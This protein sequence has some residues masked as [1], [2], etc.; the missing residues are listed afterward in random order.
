MKKRNPLFVAGFPYILISI[1]YVGMQIVT[2]AFEGEN[3]SPSIISVIGLISAIIL[4]LVGAIYGLY[5]LIDTAKVLRRE[6]GQKIPTAFLLVIPIAN[7][8]WMWRYGQVAEVYTKGKV[9]GVLVFI[10]L[11]LVGSIGM[12]ILQDTYNKQLADPTTTAP[13]SL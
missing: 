8:W 4:L 3:P 11:V 12:G 1:G 7:Y 2:G 10:L 9:Q 13:P 6:T 5:W